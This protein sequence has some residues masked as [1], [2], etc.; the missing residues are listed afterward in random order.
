MND[1]QWR[2]FRCY[3][4]GQELTAHIRPGSC[5]GYVLDVSANAGNGVVY[6]YFDHVYNNERGALRALKTRFRGAEWEELKNE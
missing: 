3:F 4:E 1:Y 6:P 5:G 2:W